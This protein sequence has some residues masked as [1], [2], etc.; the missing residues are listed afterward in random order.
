MVTPTVA[1]GIF[2]II[3]KCYKDFLFIYKWFIS[4]IKS[5]YKIRIHYST[6]EFIYKN[7]SLPVDPGDRT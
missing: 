5:T 6:G 3:P 1:G 4:D 7:I 2:R